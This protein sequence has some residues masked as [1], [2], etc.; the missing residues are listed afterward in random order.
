M[1]ETKMRAS[2]GR[3]RPASS[4]GH[5]SS[6]RAARAK[7]VRR[8]LKE[9][10]IVL[11]GSSGRTSDLYNAWIAKAYADVDLPKPWSEYSD[12]KGRVFY[13]NHN[14]GV[15][16]WEHPLLNTFKGLLERSRL[17]PD[18]ARTG[19]FRDLYYKLRK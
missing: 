2:G 9:L 13:Y 17:E 10:G 16:K 11:S 12:D 7:L 8:R 19:Y 1:S 3:S 14:S 18:L 4:R 6:K 5:R 15:S